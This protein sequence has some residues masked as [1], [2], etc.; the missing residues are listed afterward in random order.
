M[1]PRHAGGESGS[2][3]TFRL[4]KDFLNQA[5]EGKCAFRTNSIVR[6]S[7]ENV[8]WSLGVHALRPLPFLSA[9]LYGVGGFGE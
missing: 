3:M 2:E 1:C 9:A 4:R 8:E 6:Y 5:N 7:L